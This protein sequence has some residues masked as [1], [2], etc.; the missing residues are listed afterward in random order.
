MAEWSVDVDGVGQLISSAGTEAQA[1]AGQLQM[2]G[3]A[4][5]SAAE[6]SGSP[7]V[8]A[9]LAGYLGNRSSDFTYAVQRPAAMIKALITA[10]AAYI[11]ADQAMQANVAALAD[12]AVSTFS[13][14]GG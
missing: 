10:T 9:A 12:P 7:I 14:V 6:S 2:I 8:A 3:V 4:L 13:G 5:E 1:L 11:N